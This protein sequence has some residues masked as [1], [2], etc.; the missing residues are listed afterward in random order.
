M[1]SDDVARARAGD[2]DAL[3]RVMVTYRP[4]IY[5]YCRVRLDDH[6]T[7]EDVTQDVCAALYE[8]LDRHRHDSHSFAAFVFGIASNKVAM[9]YRSR[10]R[11]P[12]DSTAALPD[13]VDSAPS[14]E[15]AAMQRETSTEVRSMLSR[16]PE[17]IR[18]L[19]LLRVAAGLS[20]DE[21][22]AVLNMTPG[23]VRVAQHRAIAQLRALAEQEVRS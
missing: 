4:R 21:T 18:N 1:D 12:E 11:R 7:A 6:A 15:D 8:S 5:R 9:H 13:D 2:R 10:Y 19:L 20:A 14:P 22:A 17:H 3:H 23:A 16:L